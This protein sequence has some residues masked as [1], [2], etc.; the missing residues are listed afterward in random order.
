MHPTTNKHWEKD[1]PPEVF[2]P[3]A[4]LCKLGGSSKLR[5]CVCQL[6]SYKHKRQRSRPKISM[7]V[8][9]CNDFTYVE[10]DFVEESTVLV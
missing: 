7:S 5:R 2:S 8:F 10:D 1:P 3:T 6:V 4:V 9:L